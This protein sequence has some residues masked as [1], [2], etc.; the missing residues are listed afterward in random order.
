MI[1]K[2]DKYLDKIL[3]I[4][5][6]DFNR[7]YSV[8]EIQNKITEIQIFGKNGNVIFS[9]DLLADLR[10]A[11]TFL[12]SRKMVKL[13]IPFEDD[14]KLTFEGYLKLKT[15]SFSKEVSEKYL[16]LI[17]QRIAW[18]IPILISILALIISINNSKNYT[19]NQTKA[20]AK[21]QT[22]NKFCH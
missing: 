9:P 1:N 13:F 22:E 18:T 14:V 11:L 5:S 8:Q 20:I 15:N 4:L 16:N 12:E 17:L 2:P 19:T 3:E 10:E 7:R 6:E 21:T